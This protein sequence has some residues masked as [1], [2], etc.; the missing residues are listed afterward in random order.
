MSR[1]PQWSLSLRFPHQKSNL[2]LFNS[3]AT[4]LSEPAL[5]GLLTFHVPKTMP[6]FRCLLRDTSS[7]NTPPRISKWGSSLPPDRFVSRIFYTHAFD[8]YSL[9][10]LVGG[11]STNGSTATK[12][13]GVCY[14]CS[15]IGVLVP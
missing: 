13:S 4:A 2:Y 14:H 6:L 7:R 12:S 15:V 8:F 9:S 1:S 11:C 3:L 5:Y 10:K